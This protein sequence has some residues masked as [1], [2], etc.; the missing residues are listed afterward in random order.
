MSLRYND[1]GDK[2]ENFKF[3]GGVVDTGE[4]LIAGVVDTGDRHSF[5]NTSANFWENS[6]RLQ[7]NTLR[8]GGHLFMKRTWSR[9]SRLRLPLKRRYQALCQ[10]P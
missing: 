8:P 9:K 4:Q 7:W 6:K 1:H 2:R 5:V 10:L 3:I